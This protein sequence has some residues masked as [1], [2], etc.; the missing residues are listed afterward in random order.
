MRILFSTYPAAFDCPGGGEAMLLK[1]LEALERAGAEV[2]RFNPWRPQLDEVDVVHYFSIQGGPFFCDYVTRRG[3]PLV[4]SPVLWLTEENRRQFPMQQICDILH[5]A[6]V[7]LQFRS[8]EGATRGGFPSG[9][10][11]VSPSSTMRLTAC[12]PSPPTRACS[13]TGSRSA[14]HSC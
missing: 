11:P 6:D 7:I 13:A 10:R 12:L 8:R 14:A 1:S 9:A 3:L 2:I 4:I 5:L